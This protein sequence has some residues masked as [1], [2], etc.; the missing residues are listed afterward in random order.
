M[1][2]TILHALGAV[3]SLGGVAVRAVFVHAHIQ[4]LFYAATWALYCSGSFKPFGL[5]GKIR[6]LHRVNLLVELEFE[7]LGQEL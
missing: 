6:L 2:V 1:I 7:E 3:E 5:L 4:N